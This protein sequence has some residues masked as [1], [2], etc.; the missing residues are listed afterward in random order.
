[1]PYKNKKKVKREF[2][3][4]TFL[5]ALYIAFTGGPRMGL[6]Y[7]EDNFLKSQR[8][9]A[10]MALQHIIYQKRVK[11]RGGRENTDQGRGKILNRTVFS[12]PLFP[13]PQRKRGKKERKER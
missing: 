9:T 3:M 13:S 6:G 8:K 11:K 2:D 7:T 10:K 4:I 12:L 1:M 5:Q